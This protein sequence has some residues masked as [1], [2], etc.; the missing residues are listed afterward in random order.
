MLC[1]KACDGDPGQIG[2]PRRKGPRA[3]SVFDGV[4]ES[5]GEVLSSMNTYALLSGS[6]GGGAARRPAVLFGQGPAGLREKMVQA[7]AKRDM[8]K[9]SRPFST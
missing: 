6:Q 4:E 9:A 7:G 5:I 2:A 3:S 1:K 8:K